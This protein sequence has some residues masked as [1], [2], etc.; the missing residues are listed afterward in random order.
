[1]ACA[2]S[3]AAMTRSTSARC[4]A[5]NAALARDNTS[6]VV[7]GAEGP[8]T[9]EAVMVMA[10]LKQWP[11]TL[12]AGISLYPQGNLDIRAEFLRRSSPWFRDGA[13]AP[14]QP[15]AAALSAR[16]STSGRRREDR[17]PQPAAPRPATSSTSGA[18]P[19]ATSSTSGGSPQ[20]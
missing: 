5:T 11:P 2:Q 6:S 4:R 15:A 3:T 20:P 9:C 12:L 18:Q 10:L 13:S 17:A 14:P 7:A 16:P 1:W 8:A 19:T